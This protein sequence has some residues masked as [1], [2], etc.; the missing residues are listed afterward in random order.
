MTKVTKIGYE[1]GS[2]VRTYP[3][4]RAWTTAHPPTV[5]GLEVLI[6]STQHSG[7]STYTCDSQNVPTNTPGWLEALPK[8]QQPT[9]VL[10]VHVSH[11]VFSPKSTLG[12]ETHRWAPGCLR[13]LGTRF[14]V[15]AQV[16]TSVSWDRTPSWAQH[17][18]WFCLRFSLSLCPPH[19]ALASPSFSL[20]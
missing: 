7:K 3:R 5:W 2:S 16:T 18:A 4:W 9:R 11:T 8:P 6:P 17:S 12:K 15:L 1:S 20:K 14:L 13:W 10:C 19:P